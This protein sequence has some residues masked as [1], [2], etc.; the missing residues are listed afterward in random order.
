MAKRRER[1]Q[2]LH[3]FD[4]IGLADGILTHEHRDLAKAAQHQRLIVAEVAEDKALDMQRHGSAAF[5][6]LP[7]RHFTRKFLRRCT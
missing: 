6:R 5:K 2:Q 7:K 1:R 4:D 3:P